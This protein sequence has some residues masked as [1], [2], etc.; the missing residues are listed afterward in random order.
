MQ[1]QFIKNLLINKSVKLKFAKPYLE[2][3][4]IHTTLFSQSTTF[5]I[6]QK[7]EREVQQK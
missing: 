1:V 2:K 5:I 7:I 4:A 3:N 6:I